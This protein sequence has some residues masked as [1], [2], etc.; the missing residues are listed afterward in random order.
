MCSVS[1]FRRQLRVFEAFIFMVLRGLE[2]NF[3]FLETVPRF[4]GL[5]LDGLEGS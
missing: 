1:C 3:V 4:E 5:Y 2:L